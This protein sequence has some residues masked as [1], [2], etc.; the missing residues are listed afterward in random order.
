MPTATQAHM[1]PNDAMLGGIGQR[2][3]QFGNVN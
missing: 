2:K 3:R 1:N